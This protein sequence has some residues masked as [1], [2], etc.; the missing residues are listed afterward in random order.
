MDYGFIDNDP[1]ITTSLSPCFCVDI[2]NL[3]WR[4]N[5]QDDVLVYKDQRR[6]S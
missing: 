4:H 1:D 2:I 6:G 5:L 3:V